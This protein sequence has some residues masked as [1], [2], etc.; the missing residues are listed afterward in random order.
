MVHGVDWYFDRM[1]K[2]EI[3]PARWHWLDPNYSSAG[4]ARFI[5]HVIARTSRRDARRRL[6]H[7][8]K[9]KLKRSALVTVAA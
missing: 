8:A 9:T 1:R 6:V 7:R 5:A 2:Q 3:E 4:L